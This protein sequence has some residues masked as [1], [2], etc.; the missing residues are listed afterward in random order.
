MLYI[1]V[2]TYYYFIFLA[3]IID[4]MFTFFNYRKKMENNKMKIFQV[5]F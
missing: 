2:R 3:L 1:Y 4:D 5:Q